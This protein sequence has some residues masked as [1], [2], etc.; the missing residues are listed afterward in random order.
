V[1]DRIDA[2]R[3]TFVKTVAETSRYDAHNYDFVINV[4]GMNAETVASF[5]AQNIRYKLSL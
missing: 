5:L 1:V 4:T 3:D 2:E